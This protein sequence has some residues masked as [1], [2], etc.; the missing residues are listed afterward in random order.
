MVLVFSEETDSSTSNV[1]EWLIRW[2]IPFHRINVESNQQVSISLSVSNYGPDLLLRDGNKEI[3]LR[4]ISSVWFRRGSLP[5]LP[6]NYFATIDMPESFKATLQSHL[7]NEVEAVN[8]YVY[9]L[10][11][12]I[13]I[14]APTT[15]VVNKLIVLDIARRYGLRTPATVITKDN[16]DVREFARHWGSVI[17]KSIQD[18]ATLRKEHYHI[19]QRTSLIESDRL[20][21]L[22]TQFHYS[23]FQ[24]AI[25]KRFEVRTFV[26]KEEFYSIANFSQSNDLSLVDGR[27]LE[28]SSGK[29]NR[30]TRYQLPSKIEKAIAQLMAELNLNSGSIDF[31]V[32]Q[33]GEYY[34]LEINPVGQFGFVSSAGGYQI[35]KRIAKYF[36]D[37]YE[38]WKE[39]L[40]QRS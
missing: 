1:L 7:F 3:K 31:I 25:V 22:P 9:Y 27:N 17:T 39:C 6:K 24:Q 40:V 11:R 10:L 35:E 4:D 16:K 32:D 12:K 19:A 13:S 26:F 29:P 37:Q 38:L 2:D 23:L 5:A 14:N 30:L 15:Y 8:R 33:T 28:S 18:I 36:K 21:E 20:R 34:F